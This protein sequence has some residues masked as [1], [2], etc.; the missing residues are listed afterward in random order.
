MSPSFKPVLASIAVVALLATACSSGPPV[1]EGDTTAPTPASTTPQ[2]VTHD[3]ALNEDATWGEWTFSVS[4]ASLADSCEHSG[5]AADS[6]DLFLTVTGRVAR[7]EEGSS[8]DRPS[9]SFEPMRT[10]SA[11]AEQV[12]LTDEVDCRADDDDRPTWEE[13]SAS[14]D[15]SAF[16]SVFI[17]PSD[18]A[19]LL[20]GA[21]RETW[22]VPIAPPTLSS[23]TA[24]ATSSAGSPST[25]P[26]P[27]L[28]EC[29]FGGGAWTGQGR[30][31]DGGFQP[32]P[33]CQSLR[34]QQMA[35]NPYRCPQ[36]DHYVPG[37]EHCGGS[38][39]PQQEPQQPSPWVQ[40]QIDWVNC[41]EA[42]NTEEQ[43]RQMLNG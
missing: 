25:D 5:A 14:E 3:L 41:I 22:R 34:D 43:C 38:V 19:Y 29:I 33:E 16:R 15:G 13:V 23:S 11:D 2:L 37:P 12:V 20:V 27:T 40:G 18:A 31:S 32:V 6:G 39:S 42:G 8:T 10:E 1:G 9:E 28:V 17:A 36:T 7:S 21:E 4:D 26:G 24:A 35:A 30:M